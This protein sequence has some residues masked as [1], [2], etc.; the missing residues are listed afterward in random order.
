MKS[1]IRSFNEYYMIY[2]NEYAKY[3]VGSKN[4]VAISLLLFC[5]I[6]SF[7]FMNAKL[8][9][10]GILVSFGMVQYKINN[11]NSKL[12][13]HPIWLVMSEVKRCFQLISGRC[14]K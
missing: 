2:L 1:R 11:V 4:H 9:M 12:F 14:F 7:I 10:V 13:S 3:S 8:L 6:S 5:T